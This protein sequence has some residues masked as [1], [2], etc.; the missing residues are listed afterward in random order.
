MKNDKWTSVTLATSVVKQLRELA[1]P[2]QSLTGVVQEL[3][4]R[5]ENVSSGK[6]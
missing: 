2:G 3:I 4:N 5:V 1:R 6:S